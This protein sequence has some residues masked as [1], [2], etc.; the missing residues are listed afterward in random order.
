MKQFLKQWTPLAVLLLVAFFWSVPTVMAHAVPVDSSPAANEV[1]ADPPPDLQIRFNEPV[2]AS[3][4]QVRVLTQAG[5]RVS[6]SDLRVVDEA[7]TTLAVSFPEPLKE[8]AYLVSWQVLSS[9][10]GHTTSGTFPFG[11]GDTILTA[12]SGDEVVTAQLSVPSAIA[13]WL[14]LT[15][16]SLLLGLF[17][18]RL[19]VWNPILN[20]VELE[21]EEVALDLRFG[22]IGLR[23]GLLAIA[24]AGVALLVIFVEQAR[25]YQL[26]QLPNLQVWL[27]TQFGQMWLIRLLLVVVSH[28]NLSLFVNVKNGRFDL[29]GGEWWAGLALAIALALTNALVSHSAALTENTLLAILTDW[30]H[31][32]AAGLWV[33]GLLLLAIGVWQARALTG[34]NR[35]WLTL[36]L[37]LHFS[38]LA[39]TAVGILT[40]SGTYLA[41]RH[42]GSWTLLVGT[43]YGL[44]LL[45]KL[46]IALLMI[47]LAGFNLAVIK[48]RLSAAYDAENTAVTNQLVQRFRRTIWLEAALALVLLLAAGFLT[49]L[50]RAADAPLLADAPGETVVTSEAESLDITLHIEPALIGQNQF[51]IEVVDQNG[52]PLP[53][54]AE[55]STR[56]TFLGQSIGSDSALAERLENGRYLIEGSYISLIGSW[57]IEVAVRQPGEFDTFAPFRLE[58]GLGGNIRGQNSGARPLEQFAKFMTLA[59]TGGTGLAMILFAI[60]WGIIAVRAARTEWQLIPLLAISLFAFWQGSLHLINFF[61]KEYTPTKFLTNPVLPDAESVAIGQSLYQENCVPCHGL[62]GSGNGPAALSLNPPPADF[63]AGHTNTHPDGDLFFWI[64]EGIED[65][66][67][68]A[69]GENLTR[70]ETWH[71]VNYVRRLSSRVDQPT[72]G[73]ETAGPP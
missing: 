4:S 11:V 6:T 67:M 29:R 48:P 20:D 19:L 44:M 42:I 64:R 36:S 14:M 65:T 25:T 9:V 38:A 50:Q 46:G 57:Q 17:A 70:E 41:V 13:R 51:E 26:W 61:D 5:E 7:G 59:S 21:K 52:E 24:I 49:D 18:F 31:V 68:P 39:A 43:A 10:D 23:V 2:V 73:A 32:I 40:V 8:G 1:L 63:A 58:A 30:A 72:S 55:V 47:G 71:L 37:L 69:F 56:F 60:G 34:D 62:N 45:A 66:A 16:I 53:A 12:V 33:G 35:G 3:L 54:D 15:S 27:G 22:E 28:F